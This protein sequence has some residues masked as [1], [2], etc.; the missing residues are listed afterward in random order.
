[1]AKTTTRRS[2]KAATKK[3]ATA[4]KT[5]STRKT[6]IATETPAAPAGTAMGLPLKTWVQSRRKAKASEVRSGRRA[7]I[8]AFA[9]DGGKSQVATLSKAVRPHLRKWQLTSCLDSQAESHFFQGSEGPVWVLR[10]TPPKGERAKIGRIDTLDKSNFAKFRDLAGAVVPQL[11]AYETEKLIIE[12][13]GLSRDEEQGM[14]LGLEMASYSYQE[15]RPISPKPRRKRPALLYKQMVMTDIEADAASDLALAVNLAR[16]YTNLPGGELNPRSY[17]ESVKELFAD[18]KTVEVDIWEGEKLTRERM[19]LLL[20]VGGAAAEGPRLVHIRYRPKAAV[21]AKPVALVGKGVTFDSGG[22]DI[23]PSSGM[24]WMKKDMGGSAA[25]LAVVFWAERTGFGVPLDVYLSLAENSV[26]SRS[27]RPGD[28]IIA[29]NGS[30][31]EIGNTDAEGRL[32]MADALDVAVGKEGADEPQAV[33]DISTLT[34]AIKVALG[35]DVAGLFSNSDELANLLADAGRER[36]DLMWRMPMYQPYRSQLKSTVAD[37]N[38]CSESGFGGAITAALFLETFVGKARW[39]HLDIYAWKDSASGAW[40]ES[41]G[42]GQAV[43]A[44][45]TALARLA[46]ENSAVELA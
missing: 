34:G 45:T 26:G 19:G 31:V 2:A 20:A 25:A 3:S 23:K 15:H 22:L 46:E 35:A 29:R 24:R 9:G 5:S 4:K 12:C 17:S 32:V 44:L 28:V 43:M 36:G 8:F 21:V 39:A 10:V 27:F 37:F 30:A 42:S 13:H 14:M 33:I 7:F 11:S 40:A 38:N 1:M 41:G 18:S 16:H 6:A